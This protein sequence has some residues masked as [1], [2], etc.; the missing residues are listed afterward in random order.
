MG[1]SGGRGVAV[2]VGVGVTGVAVGLGGAASVPWLGEVA[3]RLGVGGCDTVG[4][5]VRD[6]GVCVLVGVGVESAVK[7]VAVCSTLG[8]A[9]ASDSST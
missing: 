1:T 5:A 3:E 7:L 4:L 6:A 8:A 9:G 2:G